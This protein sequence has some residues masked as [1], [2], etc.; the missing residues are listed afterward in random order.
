MVP[1][2]L[3]AGG[4]FGGMSA[5]VV[6]LALI[7]LAVLIVLCAG[8]RGGVWAATF[9]VVVFLWRFDV[10]RLRDPWNPYFVIFPTALSLVLAACVVAGRHRRA[11][12]LGLVVVASLAVQT[13]VG[14]APIVLAA[15][16]VALIFVLP[17][18]SGGSRRQAIIDLALATAVFLVAWSLPLWQQLTGKTGNLRELAYFFFKAKEQHPSFGQTAKLVTG[19]LAL[20]PAPTGDRYGVASPFL[21]PVR[22]TAAAVAVAVVVV[23]IV[24]F[25]AWLGWRSHD[26]LL[27][28]ITA[29]ALVGTLMAYVAGREIAGQ[30]Y[31]YLLTPML[32]VALTLWV[33]AA[34]TVTRAL[35]RTEL[36]PFRP[37][38]TTTIVVL[39]SV[40]AL[41]AS[42]LL[43]RSPLAKAGGAFGPIASTPSIPILQAATRSYCV[44]PAGDVTLW[45]VDGPTPSAAGLADALDR[46][47]QHV[48]VGPNAIPFGPLNSTDHYRG[49]VIDVVSPKANP[50]PGWTRLVASADTALDVQS[51]GQGP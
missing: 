7:C 43:D 48:F 16:L 4:R 11:C 41:T 42:V 29:M 28:A 2:Y 6:L 38:M 47:G 8:V 5:A 20:S 12:L 49:R 31:P 14:S 39:C 35:S 18:L 17:R 37:S 10:E 15:A 45:L 27:L 46:C 30:L 23:V 24:V 1:F 36:R 26:R 40:A 50:A 19:V 9:A 21:P 32:G 51:G 33:A 25:G 13:H 34:L 3:L 22:L 44:R